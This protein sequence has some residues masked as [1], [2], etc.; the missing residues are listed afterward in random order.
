[1]VIVKVAQGKNVIR[2]GLHIRYNKKAV[3][4]GAAN[5]LRFLCARSGIGELAVEQNFDIFH[6][7]A[8]EG[9]GNKPTNVGGVETVACREFELEIVQN[10]ALVEVG[11]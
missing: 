3:G 6:R 9:I 10:V 11:H 5:T 1:M 4:V 2:L 7:L 8:G